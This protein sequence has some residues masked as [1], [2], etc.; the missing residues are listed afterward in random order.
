MASKKWHGSKW[1][2]AD[3]RLAINLRDGMQCAY[4]KQGLEDEVVLSLDHLIP[5]S[6]GGDNHQSNLITACRKCNSARGNRDWQQFAH[7][8]ATYLNHGVTGEMI[9][10]YIIETT[11]KPLNQYR[12]MAKE[13]INNRMNEVK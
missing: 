4:C 3:K 12:K 11:N 5:R 7:D 6:H 1:L 13:I 8:T 2:R 10:N 9:V